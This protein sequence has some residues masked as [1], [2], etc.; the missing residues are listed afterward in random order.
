[1][2][3][4]LRSYGYSHPARGLTVINRPMGPGFNVRCC[5]AAFSAPSR[6]P[7][8]GVNLNSKRPTRSARAALSSRSAKL[9]PT[10]LRVP[11]LKGTQPAAYTSMQAP[12]VGEGGRL[13]IKFHVHACFLPYV[14]SSVLQQPYEMH[15]A[16]YST[17]IHTLKHKVACILRRYLLTKTSSP[18][19]AG[20]HIAS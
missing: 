6:P 18:M 3:I 8:Q 17:H 12:G 4:Y 2:R 20:M 19:I 7:I 15:T 16:C 14:R 10:Q 11:T 13:R 5:R 1:M 9:R